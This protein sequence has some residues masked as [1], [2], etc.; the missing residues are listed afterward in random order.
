MATRKPALT[1]SAEQQ[2]E[3]DKLVGPWMAAQEAADKAQEALDA[4]YKAIFDVLYPNGS[5]SAGTENWQM[6]GNWILNFDHRENFKI[7]DK[8]M[9]PDAAKAVAAI[10]QDEETGEVYSLDTIIKWKPEVSATGW[11]DAA[12]AVKKLLCEMN[13]IESNFGKAGLKLTKPKRVQ[14]QPQPV[15]GNQKIDE[16]QF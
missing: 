16:E 9:L 15:I 14:V 10:P 8:A 5:Q 12:P 7:T 2:K 4:A 13:L 3:L 11:R 1:P 6:P